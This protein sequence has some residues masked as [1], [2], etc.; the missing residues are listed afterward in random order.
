MTCPAQRPHRSK[1]DYETPKAFIKAVERRFGSL[2]YDLAASCYNV[3]AGRFFDENDDSLSQ[4]WCALLGNLWLNPPFAHIAPWARKCRESTGHGRRILLLTPASV[5][6]E[7]F[8]RDVHGR[9]LVLALRPR[10]TFVGCDACY[11]KD[12]M[13]SVYSTALSDRPAFDTWRWDA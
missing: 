7:W 11:P 8:A 10:I 3:Q 13:L 9:A 12:L 6:S 2:A 1:Q 4:D 5:G